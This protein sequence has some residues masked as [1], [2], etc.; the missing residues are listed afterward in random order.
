MNLSDAIVYDIETFPNCF[1]LAA[2]MLHQDVKGIWEISEFRDDRVQLL[3]WFEYLRANQIPMIGFNTLHFDYPVIHSLMM[4][5]RASVA[6]I[7][8]KAQDIIRSG[9]AGRVW[10]HQ[11]WQRDRFAPQIDL[12]KINHFD[13]RAKTTSLKAL[14]INMRSQSVEDM[15]VEIGKHLTH[16]EVNGSLKPYNLHDTSETKRFAHFCMEAINFRIG[17]L[18]T[19]KGD[20]LNF[21]DTKIGEQI[22]IQRIG[23]DVCF[24]PAHYE[25]N[26]FDGQREYH[27]KAPRQTIRSRIALNE[28]IFP[29][30][31]FN[32]PEFARVLTWM[33]QQILTPEELLS[34][35]EIELQ[36]ERFTPIATKGVL[37]GIKANVGGLDFHF[38]TGGIH[39]SVTPQR[40]I[41]TDEWWIVDVDV[42]GYY[43]S[44]AVANS[45][46]PAHLGDA[47]VREYGKLKPERKEWQKRKGKK[48]VEANSLKLAGNG[49]YGKSNSPFS[50]FYDPQYTMTITINCQLMLCMLAE[51][52]L[53]VPTLQII[54]ANTD[55]ITYRIHRDYEPQAIEVR[56]RWEAFTCL[57]LEDVRY[58]RMWIR[59]VNNYVAED[60]KSKLKQK[61]AYWHPDPLN[62]AQSI[63]ESQPPAWHKDLGNCVSIMAAVAAMVHGIAPETFIAMHTNKFDFMLRAKVGRS[64]RLMLGNTEL[65][66]TSRYY[67]ANNGAPLRK[68]SP[69][70]GRLGAFKRANGVSEADYLRVMN[71]NGW[72][73]D[74]SVCTKNKSKY[75][76]RITAF[77][78]GWNVA[79]CNNADAF[80]FDNI[81]YKY[82]VD[83]ARKLI[84]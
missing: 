33:K 37:K 42:E 15:P 79:E 14:Q 26:P 10:D 11:I 39:A 61:G 41:A 53:T 40:I 38:G 59:D 75:E 60:L 66:R 70:A 32:N 27:R 76:D 22:L 18:D 77:E 73:W 2:E 65:Q 81:N 5:P 24:T 71:A 31:H 74:A 3:A 1:S 25:E 49:V 23:E 84:I 6:E 67:V 43:P 7:F 56:K 35:D 30:I 72:Q 29:Y 57:T 83:E 63:S 17:L 8:A 52:L 62:Y 12:F 34:T 80:R 4:N 51:W 36:G 9:N 82:Y 28:I 19:L 69:P 46:A 44:A 78:A 16:N 13:N 68:I 50:C 58:R 20:V 21:N 48:C 55:G 45:V 47:Y 64:D 54:Q